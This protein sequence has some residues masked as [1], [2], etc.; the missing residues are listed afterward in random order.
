M[1][2]DGR[3]PLTRERGKEKGEAETRLEF[4]EEGLCRVRFFCVIE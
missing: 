2:L 4:W 1:T 3:Q